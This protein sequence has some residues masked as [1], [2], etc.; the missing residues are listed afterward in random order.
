[1]VSTILKRSTRVNK[2]PYQIYG[3]KNHLAKFSKKRYERNFDSPIA[4]KTTFTIFTYGLD[5]FPNTNS[6]H[7]MTPHLSNPLSKVIFVFPLRIIKVSIQL[8]VGDGNNFPIKHLGHF[9]LS[10][11][12]K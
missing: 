4:N 10:G 9:S 11:P 12:F 1:M 3:W 5:W 8:F 7:Y 6:S 2:G